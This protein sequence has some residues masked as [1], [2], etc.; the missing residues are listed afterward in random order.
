MKNL[1]WAVSIFFCLLVCI[2]SLNAYSQ[3]FDQSVRKY[4]S[5]SAKIIAFVDAT[6]IDGT[7]NPSKSHQTIIIDN[8]IIVKY[9]KAQD[10]KVPKMASVINC[11]GKTIIPGMVK[12]HEHLFYTIKMGAMANFAEMP[13]SFP[14]MYL[15]GGAT[16]IRTAG[17]IEPQADLTIKSL[18]NEGIL[19]GPDIDVTAPY[20]E[21]KGWEIPAFFEVKDSAE[22]AIMVNFWADRGCTSFK[23]YVF[24]TKEDMIAVIREAHKRKL[25]VTG[26][27]GTITYQEAAESGIDNLEHGFMASYDFDHLR[28]KEGFDFEKSINALGDLD[29]SSAE[30]QK[31]IHLLI[32]KNVALTSTLPVIK[33]CTNSE[34]VLGGGDSALL[35]EV[36][37]LVEARWKR[38]QNNDSDEVKLFK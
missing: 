14:R 22:A 33:P 8:G 38:I 28:S 3:N 25:K 19:I 1:K 6:V 23:L 24:A 30:M 18:I 34:I 11:T 32:K 31:L 2:S 37:K 29:T 21:R 26:H 10:I 16:T 36:M 7:G 5:D 27:L 15:A 12:L 35:P 20:I 17:S 9:G 13:Y 4:I